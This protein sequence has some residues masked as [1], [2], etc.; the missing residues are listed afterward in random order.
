[1]AISS[2]QDNVSP[3]RRRAGVS[4]PLCHGEEES[5]AA[6]LVEWHAIH[7]KRVML[8]EIVHINVQM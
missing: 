2:Q 8:R 1:M 6:G 5:R 4:P 3:S 7:G